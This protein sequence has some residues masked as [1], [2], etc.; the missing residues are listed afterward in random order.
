M[1]RTKK[2]LGG[3]WHIGWNVGKEIHEDRVV[4]MANGSPSKNSFALGRL[5]QLKP[6]GLV[7]TTTKRN[8]DVWCSPT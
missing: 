2:K 7:V 4:N 1:T 3:I 6:P 8:N 5:G